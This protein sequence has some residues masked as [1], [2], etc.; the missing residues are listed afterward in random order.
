M[1]MRC[2]DC[3][4]NQN[5]TEKKEAVARGIQTVASN[6]VRYVCPAHETEVP[7][8]VTWWMFWSCDG[9]HDPASDPDQHQVFWGCGRTFSSQPLTLWK[10]NSVNQPFSL[11]PWKANSVKWPLILW[12]ANNVNRSLILWR[13]GKQYKRTCNPKRGTCFDAILQSTDSLCRK[14][15]NKLH[16]VFSVVAC[17]T[18]VQGVTWYYITVL[19]GFVEDVWVFGVTKVVV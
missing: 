9:S 5:I 12:K 6:C 16:S 7:I 4:Y 15:A 17:S 13:K 10:A 19:A 2:V 18:N 14:F 8:Q 11:I 1:V 3:V